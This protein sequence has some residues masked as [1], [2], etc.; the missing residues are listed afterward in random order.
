MSGG[1]GILHFEEKVNI[2]DEISRGIQSEEALRVTGK[3]CCLS[4]CLCFIFLQ[5][6]GREFSVNSSLLIQIQLL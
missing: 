6:S 2:R 3:C 5:I 1:A 4:I